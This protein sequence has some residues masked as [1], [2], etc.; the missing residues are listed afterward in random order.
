AKFE[1]CVH[2]FADL[3]E[4]GYG[5]AI[6]NDSKYGFSTRANVMS[7]T[8]LKAPKGPDEHCDIGTH[9]FRYAVYPHAGTFHESRVVREAHQFN[10]PLIART[11]PRATLDALGVKANIQVRSR[12]NVILDTVKRAEDSNHLI[13]RLYEAHGGQGRVQIRFHLPVTK[14]Q[15]C[16]I[17][18]EDGGVEVQADAAT[19]HY[20]LVLRPFEVA[21][22]KLTVG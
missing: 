11:R 13:V 4:F 5:V 6:L 12:G 19:G 17:L 14:V 20:P 1:V 7:L 21:S 22:L 10:V 15:R 2:K 16:N 8:L 3:S 18:E 9:R